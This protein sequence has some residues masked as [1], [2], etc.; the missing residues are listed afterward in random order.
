MT[1]IDLGCG[2]KKKK[3]L[4][5]LDSVESS[6]VDIVIDMEKE[7]LPFED[8]SIEYVYSSHFLEHIEEHI[9]VFKEISRVCKDKA[10]V[11]L[12]TPY[13]WSNAAFVFGHK[14]FFSE[15]IYLHICEK[16]YQV[17]REILSACWLLREIIFV[18]SPSTLADL[19]T[20][21]IPLGFAINHLPNI[22]EEIGVVINISHDLNTPPVKPIICFSF[23]RN[24]TR[25]PVKSFGRGRLHKINITLG[26]IK[27]MG[28]LP[29]IQFVSKEMNDT[30]PGKLLRPFSKYLT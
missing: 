24:S 8:N 26:A 17:W 7:P 12:W 30:L 23:G 29:F 5:G 6:D 15:E 11:E 1:G 25:F 22:V 13:V 10:T 27:E 18:I 20:V 21:G 14:F 3:G 2:G 19:N 4:I 9:H 16:H 28:F